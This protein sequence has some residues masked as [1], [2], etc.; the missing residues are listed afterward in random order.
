MYSEKS[1]V[2]EAIRDEG[3]RKFVPKNFTLKSIFKEDEVI[4]RVKKQTKNILENFVAIL[5]IVEV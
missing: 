5:N 3:H 2:R 4:N 1:A